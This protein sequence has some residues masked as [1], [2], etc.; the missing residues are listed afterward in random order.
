MQS[1]R[2]HIIS[3]ELHEKCA[4]FGVYSPTHQAAR[5]VC[6]GLWALQH[7][8]QEATGISAADGILLRTNK[9]P[10]LVAAVHTEESLEKLPGHFAIGH[11]RYSTFGGIFGHFQPVT[12]ERNILALAHNGNLPV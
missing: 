11:N 6:T 1:N 3:S 7:R 10:G 2:K 8:G 9:G 4:V 12:T 5:L